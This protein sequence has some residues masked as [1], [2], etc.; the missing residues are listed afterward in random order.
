MT[1]KDL[2]DTLTSREIGSS[3]SFKNK[4]TTELDSLARD[5]CQA[6]GCPDDFLKNRYRLLKDEWAA[7]TALRELRIAIKEGK[8]KIENKAAYYGKL[9]SIYQGKEE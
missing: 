4:T 6:T 3:P 8:K 5:I 7:T 9:Y 1:F 2:N